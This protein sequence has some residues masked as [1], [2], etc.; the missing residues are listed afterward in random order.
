MKPLLAA[1]FFLVEGLVLIVGTAMAANGK[2][3]SVLVIGVL[4]FGAMFVKLGCLDNA[5]TEH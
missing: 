2:G 1:L 4:I 5:P 3:F